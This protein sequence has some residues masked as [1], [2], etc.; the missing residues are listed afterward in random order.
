MLMFDEES[1]DIIMI[2][3]E[4]LKRRVY[5]AN[6]SL[7]KQHLVILTWGN[8]SE[9]SENSKFMAIKPSGVPYEKLKWQDIVVLEIDT[10]KVIDGKLKPSSDTDTHIEIYR[11]F[12]EIRGITHTHST[13][14]T[15]FAQAGKAIKAY[16]TT[17]A[18]TFY[19]DVPCTRELRK[20][21]VA[22]NYELNTG[23]VIV[24]CFKKEKIN[25]LY[26]P[27]VLV[28]NHGPFVFGKDA[29]DSVHNAVILEEVAKMNI[30]TLLINN[31]PSMKQYI[32]DKHFYRKH[33]KYATYGQ[34]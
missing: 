13:Y 7:A 23:K 16:G 24:S 32:L 19:G 15:S 1:G 29:K 12:K 20:K 14:A 30:N 33:G 21:E 28:K 3:F 8:V 18:D 11:N 22:N 25:P 27:A 34:T 2:N 4:N 5:E 26:L 10:G 17:H 31:K 9:R 6:I